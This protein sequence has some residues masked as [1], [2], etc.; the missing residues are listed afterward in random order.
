MLSRF[1]TI[2]ITLYLCTY[3]ITMLENIITFLAFISDFHCSILVTT[4]SLMCLLML[5]VYA[6]TLSSWCCWTYKLSINS[7]VCT[8]CHSMIYF[9]VICTRTEVFTLVSW[10]TITMWPFVTLSDTWSL[11]ISTTI[12]FWY[13]SLCAL[14]LL[15]ACYVIY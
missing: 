6:V 1:Q 14:G 3:L 11:W 10:P 9:V 2:I 13:Y 5:F 4:L 7:I 8:D 12:L 15:I